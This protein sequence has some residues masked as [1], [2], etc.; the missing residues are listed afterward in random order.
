[1]RTRFLPLG[2]AIAL[3]VGLLTAPPAAA[4]YGVE[5]ITFPSGDAEFYSPFSGPASIKFTFNGTEND[6]TFQVR[7]RPAGGTAIHTEDVFVDADDPNGFKVK[8][9]KWPAIS[10]NGA[11]TYVVA[12]YRNGAHLASESFFLHPHLVKITGV[13]PNPFFPWIDDGYKDTTNVGFNLAADSDAQARV[14]RPNRAGTCCGALVRNADLG[15]LTAGSHDW[16]WDGRDGSGANLAKGDYFVRIRA[17]DGVVAPALSRATKVAIARTY[18]AT[19][20][21]S[22]TASAYHHV[23]P[24]TSLVI[25]GDC[26]V[27]RSNG[28][29]QI[30][31]QGGRVSVY[32]RWGL[33][34][35][36][37]IQRASFVLDTVEGCPR[38]IRRTGH[39]KHGSSFTMNE[40]LVGAAGDCRLATARIT[41]TYPRPS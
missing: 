30:L 19:A 27:Y 36:E 3:A 33:S 6:A 9:F 1:M 39:T 21:K 16:N 28:D 38:S 29:L 34:P 8:T 10:V 26:I 18:R 32:W 4:S 20:T 23:G 24:V 17:D 25:G 7:L 40:D 22:K 14:F 2:A 5:S 11:K 15:P 35:A 12:V 13:G 31:C 37:R 41:Y